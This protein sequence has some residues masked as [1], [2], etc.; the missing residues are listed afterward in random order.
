MPRD[1]YYL[2]TKVGK[3][4][5]P[6]VWRRYA[7]LFAGT[8]SASL[9][10]SAERLGTDY[11]DIIHIHDIEYQGRRHT[12]WALSE[13]LDAVQRIEAR[14]PHRRRELRHLSD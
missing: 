2:S 12:E 8:H 4:T 1:R 13:G 6:G 3:Y 11:F 7:R 14:G 9:D 5:N 10:E